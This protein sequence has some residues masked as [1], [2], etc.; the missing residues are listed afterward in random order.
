MVAGLRLG[1]VVEQ[2]V[3]VPLPSVRC[4]KSRFLQKSRERHL[5]PPQV[6]LRVLRQPSVDP[7]PIWS[8]SGEESRTRGTAHGTRRIT[9]GQ[10]DAL[11]RER[12][13]IWRL[14]N[15]VAETAQIAIAQI[16]RKEEDYVWRS[17][18]QRCL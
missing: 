13:K 5:T 12:I 4:R 18:G 17:S 16:I 7:I 11:L 6:H 14:D 15:G 2:A 1:G 9:L 10:T 3:E 8:A